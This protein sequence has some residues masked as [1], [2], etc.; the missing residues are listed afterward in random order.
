ML[1]IRV[2]LKKG[3]KRLFG[4]KW[5][6][7]EM[8]GFMIRNLKDGFFE[9]WFLL[10]NSVYFEI[11]DRVIFLDNFK[12][13]INYKCYIE[14]IKIMVYGISLNFMCVVKGFYIRFVFFFKSFWFM[15]KELE[16]WDSEILRD[17]FM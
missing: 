2:V 10:G 12:I 4:F 8:F 1:E 14:Y 13:I 11:Y 9:I 5:N 3:E 6:L 15:I 16:I 17:I 7:L